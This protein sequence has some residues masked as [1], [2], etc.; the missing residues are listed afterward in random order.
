VSSVGLIILA[1]G[2]STRLGAPKQLLTYRGRPLLRHAAE[3][4]LASVCRPVLVV[5]GARADHTEAMVDG[6]PVAIV[7]NTAWAEGIGTS[8]ACGLSAL[9]NPAPLASPLLKDKEQWPAL[10]AVVFAVCDQTL[11]T[12]DVFNDLVRT[13][14]VAGR[15]IVAS[16]YGGSFGVPALFDRS[17]FPE[18]LDLHEAG[19]K[20][21]ILRDP[22]RVAAVD[23][24]GGVVDIDTPADVAQLGGGHQ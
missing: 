17:V 23:F 3:T 18:L 15:A 11:V 8:I 21:V 12:A 5:V 22:Q 14:D 9:M 7:E 2:A 24:P 16:A 19:A 6:L 13:Y 20:S 4:A 1:A 10:D